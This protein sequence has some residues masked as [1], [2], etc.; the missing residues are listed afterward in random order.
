MSSR[1]AVAEPDLE[2]MGRRLGRPGW[3][4]VVLSAVLAVPGVVLVAF[5]HSWAL[6]L[7][8][9]IL[10]LAVGPALVGV[11]L[12]LSSLVARWSARHKSFA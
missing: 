9:V 7:G 12:L 1:N 11:A 8:V 2:R 4:F 5:T 6:A 10:A 3:W